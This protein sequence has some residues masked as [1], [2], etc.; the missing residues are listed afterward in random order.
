MHK[1][2]SPTKSADAAVEP[3]RQ[4]S[5]IAE[6]QDSSAAGPSAAPLRVTV[7]LSSRATTALHA[8]TGLTGD[9]KTEAI[10]KALQAYALIQQAQHQGGGAWLQDNASARPSQI[11]FY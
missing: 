3:T 6:T 2:M 1:S 4:G 9:S 5:G 11:R 10:N 8:I 7:N